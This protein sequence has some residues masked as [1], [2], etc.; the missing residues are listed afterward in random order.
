MGKVFLNKNPLN[1]VMLNTAYLNGGYKK[2]LSDVDENGYVKF[3][4]PE[5]SRI[6]AENWGDGTGTSLEQI[7]AVKDLNRA[8]Y[9]NTLIETF[10]EF[11]EFTNT[12]TMGI[13]GGGMEG[14]SNL[15]SI[16]LPKSFKDIKTRDFY[17]CTSL[18]S[19]NLEH[20]ESIGAQSFYGTTNLNIVLNLPNLKSLLESFEG[21]GIVGI[22]N[23]GEAKN[24]YFRLC[25]N[26][27][28]VS[29][30]VFDKAV[31]V[32]FMVCSS[33][34]SEINLPLLEN[35][36]NG[37]N[38]CASIKKVTN[39]GKITT[40]NGVILGESAFIRCSN[41]ELVVLP[42]TLET[43]TGSAYGPFRL[44]NNLKT[45]ICHAITPPSLQSNLGDTHSSLVIYVPDA[46]V[47]A[48]KSA[49][50]WVTYANRI[51]PLSEYVE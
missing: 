21:S 40:L 10:D 15:R 11:E 5:V 33:L 19:I 28:T 20:I 23:L 36:G 31:S 41:L 29:Q 3:K 48:Y 4:D 44:C 49:T 6:V 46:S 12:T 47:E 30:S 50:N 13:Y 16:K 1:I 34:E 37:F 22:E 35:L 42:S 39:L 26:L 7:Q 32:N 18:S 38:D 2:K 8:F 51:K 17:N 45:I 27:K 24:L 43:I 14:C 25:R 9:K